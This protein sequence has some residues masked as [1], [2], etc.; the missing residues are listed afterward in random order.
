V[1]RMLANSSKLFDVV[2]QSRQKGSFGGKIT[3]RLK[4]KKSPRDHADENHDGAWSHRRPRNH[5]FYKAKWLS[6]LSGLIAKRFYRSYS[7]N[8]VEL[9]KVESN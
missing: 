3:R 2:T 8:H 7:K 9:L 6:N 1:R 4:N 5:E